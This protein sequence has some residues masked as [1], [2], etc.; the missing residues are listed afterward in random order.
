MGSPAKKRRGKRRKWLFFVDPLPF[1]DS[2]QSSSPNT[3][4]RGSIDSLHLD[5]AIVER[6]VGGGCANDHRV[7]VVRS[8]HE[9]SCVAVMRVSGTGHL[10]AE[11]VTSEARI[12][13][14]CNKG[15]GRCHRAVTYPNRSSRWPKQLRTSYNHSGPTLWP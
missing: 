9:A 3:I 12:I 11:L 6:E 8:F 4:V 7:G 2:L 14:L 13:L 5:E 15:Q 10:V 1:E